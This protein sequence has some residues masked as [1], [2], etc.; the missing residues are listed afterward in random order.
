MS[1]PVR[2]LLPPALVA[3]L[4][5]LAAGCGAAA[6][7]PDAGLH[8][9][10]VTPTPSAH[11]TAVATPGDTEADQAFALPEGVHG[12]RQAPAPGAAPAAAEASRISPGAP[13]DDE[14]RRELAE[15]DRVLRAQRTSTA[16]RRPVID[17]SGRAEVPAGV[18]GAVA[19]II[20]GGNAIARFP[21]VYGGGHAS[22]V[23][24]AYDCSASVSYALAAAGLLDAPL[25]SGQL[26]S[27]GAPG[28]GRWITIYANAGHTFMYV[29][30]LRF[31]T[32]GGR[33]RSARGGRPRRARW[34]ASP[35]ATRPACSRAQEQPI[36]IPRRHPSLRGG[37]TSGSLSRRP[38]RRAGSR[39]PATGAA[40][41]RR[42]GPAGR[43]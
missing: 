22:F 32:S 35:C 18:P 9:A 29:D 20:A 37:Q 21:Y 6:T 7:G 12:T 43:R 13:S 11:H 25:T 4:A 40:P 30:G 42:C 39:A 16:G 14:V 23:D 2:R 8:A 34:Q 17:R 24:T 10:V 1:L 36:F 31:D 19:R 27:W 3:V 38:G 26:A 28:P 33:A 41:R 15:M 5:A